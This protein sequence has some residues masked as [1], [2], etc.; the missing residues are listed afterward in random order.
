[1]HRTTRFYHIPKSDLL[2]AAG[3][4]WAIAG[5]NIIR[6]GLSAAKES[7]TFLSIVAAAIAFSLF[8]F[9]FSLPWL[10]STIA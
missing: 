6:I 7:W 3:P 9:S 5:L 1:M 2:L 4:V 8:S 10:Q